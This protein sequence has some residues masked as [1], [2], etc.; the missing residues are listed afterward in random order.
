MALQAV[1]TLLSPFGYDVPASGKCWA[2]PRR[3]GSAPVRPPLREAC[4]TLDQGARR[5]QNFGV[6]PRSVRRSEGRRGDE[7]RSAKIVHRFSG[8]SRLPAAGRNVPLDHV[9]PEVVVIT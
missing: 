2:V 5:D 9:L 1:A 4:L 6:V 3:R 7:R 8:F